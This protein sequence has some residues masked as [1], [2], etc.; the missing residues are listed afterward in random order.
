MAIY[1][2]TGT[3]GLEVQ[4][5]D[6]DP[7]TCRIEASYQVWIEPSPT[8]W[9]PGMAAPEVAAQLRHIRC[10]RDGQEIDDSFLSPWM[11][12]EVYRIATHECREDAEN[13]ALMEWD[14]QVD[15]AVYA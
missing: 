5:N 8:A 10:F 1:Y 15:K 7:W 11:W 2:H 13:F 12:D 6:L 14:S 9:K 3:S 4:Q